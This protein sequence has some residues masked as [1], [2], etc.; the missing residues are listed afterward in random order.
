MKVVD[1]LSLESLQ[2]LDLWY[3]IL[4]QNEAQSSLKNILALVR[5]ILVIPVQTATIE[6]GFSLM[7][8]VKNDWRNKLTPQTLSQLIMIRLN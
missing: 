2:Y 8:R 5:I 3:K 1:A 7:L 4:S 6:C